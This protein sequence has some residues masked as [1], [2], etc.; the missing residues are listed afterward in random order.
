MKNKND[1]EFNININKKLGVA[2]LTACGLF[3]M[4][5]HHSTFSG[6]TP[7]ISQSETMTVGSVVLR[8]DD[9]NPATIYGGTWEL[10]QGDA[11]LR[12][13]NGSNLSGNIEGITNDPSVP[14]VKHTH[15]ATQAAHSHNRGNMEIYG[16]IS[17]P[18]YTNTS[19]GYSL[20]G[21]GAFAPYGS[22]T[23]LD[24]IDHYPNQGS[25]YRS[26]D[27]RA[28]RNWTGTTNSV[29]PVITVEEEGFDNPTI[30]VRGNYITVNVWKRVS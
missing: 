3:A 20:S 9:V 7:V 4:A 24:D 19:V 2:L 8:M 28:S 10:I 13:G 23:T 15:T 5:E 21:T 25:V 27:F 14:L 30:D 26:V 18:G 17:A 11:D 16:R 6:D 12:L 22:L 29:A 1:I